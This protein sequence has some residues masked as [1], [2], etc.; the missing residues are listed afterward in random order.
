MMSHTVMLA[1]RRPQAL[2]RPVAVACLCLAALT[3]PAAAQAPLPVVEGVEAAPF[4]EHCRRLLEAIEPL[5]LLSLEER[6]QLRELLRGDVN[7]NVVLKLQAL[8]DRHCL[9]AVNINPESR[10]KAAR[11]PAPAELVL[12]RESLALIRVHNEAG[13][14]DSLKISGPQLS[15]TATSEPARWLDLSV[16]VDK[17]LGK[18]LTGD[19]LEYVVVR[20]KP[21]QA[22]KREAT[23]KFDVGQGTQDLGFRAEVP[24]LFTIKR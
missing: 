14:S 1:D 19:K 16:V 21:R 15:T 6:Q 20:L 4:H 13:V 7:A 24:V 17:P 11:G 18:T 12:D 22:G 10:V 8:L 5:P 9:V 23:L 3:S 2:A